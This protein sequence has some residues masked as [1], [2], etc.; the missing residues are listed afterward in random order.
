[1]GSDDP[2][3]LSN[4]LSAGAIAAIVV[5]SV[6]GF[7]LCIIFFGILGSLIK[8]C[9]RPR[10]PRT[11]S[12]VLRHPYPYPY[13]YPH[14]WATQYPPDV[15]SISNDPPPYHSVPPPYTASAPAP[16]KSPYT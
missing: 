11:Q 4:I 8:H 1:M 2:E 9:S 5:G 12:P 13:P 15:T 3:T 10:R 14:S 7:A 16:P 6:I